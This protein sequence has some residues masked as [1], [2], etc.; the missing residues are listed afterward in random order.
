MNKEIPT[1]LG[2]KLKIMVLV[3]VGLSVCL[4]CT[5]SYAATT[6]PETTGGNTVFAGEDPCLKS[7][8]E[9]AQGKKVVYPW[10]MDP[11]KVQEV[12][13]I[14]E[15]KPLHVVNISKKKR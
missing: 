10:G 11:C 14:M 1:K 13:V 4:F 5:N 8:R 12:E 9:K 2:K 15:K 6:A 3:A 7:L